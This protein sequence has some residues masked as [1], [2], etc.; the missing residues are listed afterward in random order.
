MDIRV[1]ERAY[2]ERIVYHNNKAI[3]VVVGEEFQLRAQGSRVFLRNPQAIVLSTAEL[4]IAEDMGAKS[5]ALFDTESGTIYSAEIKEIWFSGIG[6]VSGHEERIALDM[7]KWHATLPP[8]GVDIDA[9][10][11]L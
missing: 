2:A 1:I 10:A 4:R 3:G 6:L 8:M 9:Y 7:H 5:V 11:G